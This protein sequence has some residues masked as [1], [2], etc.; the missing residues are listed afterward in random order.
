M[1]QRYG[2]LFARRQREKEVAQAYKDKGKAPPPPPS[3]SS[4]LLLRLADEALQLN[5]SHHFPL[6]KDAQGRVES[7]TTRFKGGSALD[8]LMKCDATALASGQQPHSTATP[9]QASFVLRLYQHGFTINS[10]DDNWQ[11]YSAANLTMLQHIDSG[12]IPPYFT[13]LSARP[14]PCT[15][16]MATSSVR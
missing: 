15:S 9:L 14:C 13:S 8:S 11:E 16:S 1:Q 10:E 7:T 5:V 2:V 6:S 12:L 3:S 4:T